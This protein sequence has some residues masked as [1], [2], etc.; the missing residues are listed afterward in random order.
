VVITQIRSSS[1]PRIRHER[2][3]KISGSFA[4]AFWSDITP[5]ARRRE[6]ST[7][8]ADFRRSIRLV[9]I[10]RL[11]SVGAFSDLI[12][13]SSF[14]FR[15]FPGA[16]SIRGRNHSLLAVARARQM[17]LNLETSGNAA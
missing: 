11:F 9:T 6:S 17:L 7:D 13:I 14:D 10:V 4:Q 1:K 3:L 5:I 2:K 16:C 8:Y 15:H 12:R